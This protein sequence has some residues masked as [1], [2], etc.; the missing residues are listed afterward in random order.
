MIG[1]GYSVVEA[2]RPDGT[3]PT[4][5]AKRAVGPRRGCA[6]RSFAPRPRLTYA[7]V[8]ATL[9]LVL[10]MSGGAL[11]AKRFL[12]T[13]RGQI[14]PRVHNGPRGTRGPAG[15]TERPEAAGAALSIPPTAVRR[16]GDDHERRT[17]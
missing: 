6:R 11:A 10:S 1:H 9:A 17:R 2:A 14:S 7:N 5:L 13:S 15:P 12:I 16:I 8:L 3:P 4:M